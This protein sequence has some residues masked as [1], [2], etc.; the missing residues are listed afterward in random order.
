MNDGG[1]YYK[2]RLNFIQYNG[3]IDGA[4]ATVNSTSKTVLVL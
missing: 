4:D 2:F 3:D 1:N